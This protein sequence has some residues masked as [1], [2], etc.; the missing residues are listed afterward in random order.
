MSQTV[1]ENYPKHNLTDEQL[2]EF[3][4]Q[5]LKQNEVKTSGFPTEFIELPSKGKAYPENHPLASGR[6]EMK[7][8]TAR[9]EDILTSTNLIEQG[10]VLDKLMDSMIVSPVKVGDLVIGDKNAV[11]VAARV[12]GYGK[13][14]DVVVTCPKCGKKSNM[15]IDLTQLP[16]TSIPEETEM[17][18]SGVFEFTLP[19]SQRTVH[20]KLMTGAE[21]DKITKDLNAFKKKNPNS[22][23]NEVTTRL[24]STI[25][26]VDGNSDA[27]FVSNFVDNE[28]F[29][30][31]ARALRSYIASI[32]P[33]IKFEFDFQ[34]EH[35]STHEA[36]AL[37]FDLDANFFWPKS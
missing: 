15:S 2:K 29:A 5:Q 7:Y 4:L 34:C 6:I 14:Y 16:T 13:N 31:D 19:S 17:V 3:A 8:M 1:N 26:A 18:T 10:I 30:M 20:F 27:K 12:L 24:K 23:V 35:D 37:G 22:V 25:V 32:T 28:L 33:D 9:E 36:E 21:D 11:M